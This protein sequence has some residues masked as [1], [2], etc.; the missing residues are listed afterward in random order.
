VLTAATWPPWAWWTWARRR[1]SWPRSRS[2]NPGTQLTLRTFHIGGTSARI[3][4]KTERRTKL[5]GTDRIQR[6]GSCWWSWKTARTSWTGYEGELI[7][8]TRTGR[9]VR[10]SKCRSAPRSRSNNKQK[11]KKDDLLFEWDPYT[12]PIM[13]D[14]TGK[15]RF[16]DIVEDETVREELDEL[17]GL[18][19]RVI[20][21]DRD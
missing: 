7:P 19:Q 6:P 13:T 3:A 20:I 5:E 15:A 18:R 14:V 21:E 12:N 9:S 17:T 11:I 2:A 16:V 4:E 8:R 10:G 1:A